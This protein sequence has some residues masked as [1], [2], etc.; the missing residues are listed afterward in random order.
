MLKSFSAARS[1]LAALGILSA[2]A[3]IPNM[4]TRGLGLPGLRRPGKRYPEQSARQQLRAYRRAQGG[5]G[6]TGGMNPQPRL[7]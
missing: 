5:P 2:G 6:L 4:P 3:S 1:L 7:G